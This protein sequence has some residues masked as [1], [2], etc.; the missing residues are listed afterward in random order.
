MNNP[1]FRLVFLVSICLLL[2]IPGTS[3]TQTPP[4]QPPGYEEMMK[5]RQKRPSKEAYFEL[6]EL[7]EKYPNSSIIA[8]I[9]SMLTLT[10]RFVINASTSIDEILDIQKTALQ[11]GAVQILLQ[12]YLT[13]CRQIL[14]HNNIG[15]FDMKE[16]LQAIQYYADEGKKLSNSPQFMA[17]W[18]ESVSPAI[19]ARVQST[20]RSFDMMVAA[21]YVFN[22]NGEKAKEYLE[23]YYNSGGAGEGIGP[24]PLPGLSEPP[25][26]IRIRR[27]IGGQGGTVSAEYYYY[28]GQTNELLEKK[29]EALDAY[30]SAMGEN[31]KD[32]V[33]KAKALFKE[34]NGNMEEFDRMLEEKFS[35]LPFQPDPF[36]LSGEWK[37]KAVLAE[38]FTGSENPQSAATDIAFAALLER[39]DQQYLTILE[40]HVSRAPQHDPMM[41]AASDRR[42]AFYQVSATPST[43]FDGVFKFRGG[44]AKSA[45]K[46]KYDQY[47]T[48]IEPGLTRTP[49]AKLQ[50]S[51][52][53]EGDIVKV[54]WSSDDELEAVNYNFA[55]VQN[56]EKYL[57]K[58]GIY[59]H[60]MI[61]RDFKSL[62]TDV[63]KES[64]ITFSVPDIFEATE[65]YLKAYEKQQRFKFEERLYDIDRSQ[66]KVVLFVQDKDTQFVYNAIVCD[67]IVK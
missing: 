9:N 32:S 66:L 37:G 29:Q 61:V 41:N 38:L 3:Y 45:A 12:R 64:E 55:L 16:V 2:A 13:S 21:A 50:L 5:I 40:Y 57:G 52:V 63:E 35:E 33:S 24:S 7:K 31:Y 25:V 53:L 20:A 23:Y 30:I 26:A 15:S 27:G 4:N 54:T 19:E 6:L 39:Y 11:S 47:V 65:T 51:A 67:V 36:I 49:P 28:L 1:A 59:I 48:S 62:E 34:I 42:K 8:Q 46:R 18:M 17:G 44:G 58:S 10:S 56:K 14:E 22:K 43:Y 60:N